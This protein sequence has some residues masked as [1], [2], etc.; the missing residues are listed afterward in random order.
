MTTR[1]CIASLLFVL[2]GSL[3]PA[4]SET[5]PSTAWEHVPPESAGLDVK[6]LEQA[7][8]Y[9][10]SG[11]GSGFITHHGKAVLTWGDPKQRY[12]LKSTSK[13]IGVT[14]LGLALA[15]GKLALT[16]L[17]T[18][19]HP[20]FGQPPPENA[21][22][23]WLDDITLLHLAT[24]TAGFAKPGGYEKLLFA[25]GSH[26]HYSDGGPNWLAECV[27]HAYRR[28]LNEVMFERVFSPLGITPNDLT[29][30]K[31]AYRPHL[32]DGM[33][34]R[35]FGSGFS[36]NVDAM[37][38]LG[39]LY[40][41]EGRWRDQQIIPRDFVAASRSPVASVVGLPEWEGDPHG[42]A[43]DHYGLL[44]WNN[45]D[46]TL[47]NVPRDAYW[48]WGLYDSLIVVVP[49]LDLV[50]ARAG[51]SW[52]RS[53]DE[54]YAVLAPFLEPLTAA[55]GGQAPYPPSPVI[56]SMTWAAVST[57]VRQAPGSDNWPITWGD[58]GALYTVYGD[59]HGFEPRVKE[60]L[61]LGLA[62][63]T[64]FADNFLAENLRSTTAEQK[65]Q[66]AAGKKA[67]GMLMVDGVLYLWVRNAG[68][69]QLAWS[70]DRGLTWQ[71]SDWRW[72]ES[73]GCPTFLNFGRNYAGARDAFVYVY[74]HDHDDAYEPA[75]GIV[76]ARVPKSNLT[77]QTA[78]QFFAGLDDKGQPRWTDNVAQRKPA[79]EHPGRCYRV[80]VSYHTGSKRYLLRHT[81]PEGDPRF[82]GGFSVYDAPE[83]WGP[84][85]TVFFTN[86]WDMGPGETGAFPTTW[87]SADGRTVT[88]VFSGDDSFS[89]R[90]AR[91]EF[92]PR[93]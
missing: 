20:Q 61:S 76:L 91:L 23:G 11:G 60:K 3:P 79:F 15:D 5:W 36:A 21:K 18:D 90:Q 86:R 6:Q 1:A 40:L 56:Q 52:N 16:D 85:T 69:S 42:N 48:S 31:H 49:S 44:W 53:S 27:T 64:G 50:A 72:Q 39:L 29:W 66:G 74:S 78:Y 12:D 13:S 89:V 22:T 87:M 26:W 65:G 7:R 83:P 55:A 59:G 9:A 80:S 73:F 57:V 25:P 70:A 45:A 17:A 81:H 71:W 38:R 62:R 84:W 54:H 41:R 51:Q 2:A 47:K 82:A 75:D 34:R 63:I 46:G 92:A 93:E 28:D 10:L 35:E 58:D 24:Q 67:S 37:A 30:R 4:S 14:A 32:V 19:R 33:P 77:D 88:M 43:S 8:D 68:N